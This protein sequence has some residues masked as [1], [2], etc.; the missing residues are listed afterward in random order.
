M[1][2]ENLPNANSSFDYTPEMVAE[3]EKCR[4]DII[5]FAS[6]YFYIIDPDS[7]VGKV[8][9]NL[10]EFQKRVLKGIF[11]NR[12]NV[13]LSPRQASKALAL[14]TPI[15][16][17]N[18][19]TTMG[20]LKDGDVVYG[21][22]GKPCNVVMAHNIRY[23]RPCYEVEFDN[24]EVIVAD[25]DHNWFIQSKRDRD[26]KVVSCGS[27]KT[28]KEL[29]ENFKTKSGEP[30]YRIPS[31]INGV[32][33]EEKDL[34]I[35]P[36]VLG[37]WL[38]DGS[39]DSSRIT[40]GYQYIDELREILSQY[41]RYKYSEVYRE[42][43]NI[44]SIN[45]G[46]IDGKWDKIGYRA[47]LNNDLRN[48]NLLGNKHIP[49][50]YL[51]S[52]R[53]QRLELLKGL[54]D[55]D[56]SIN[57]R[58][59]ARFTNKNENLVNQFKEL[60]ESLG[61]KTTYKVRKTFLNGKQCADSHSIEYYPRE[62][63][64][65]L[66]FKKN[67]IVLQNIQEPE[68]NK[69]NQWHYIKDIRPIQSVPVRC[70][71][72]DSSDNLFLC[73]K[74]FIPTHN[75]TMITIMALH[76]ACFKAYRN[77]VIV[78]NKEATAIEIF[79]RVRLAYEE[80]P[81]W[82]KPGVGEYGKTGCVFDNGSR[83]S[84]STTTGS[85]SRGASVSV[86]IIDEIGW[87]ENHLL[88]EF[89][90]SVYPTISRSRTSKIIAASTPNGVGNLFH[91]L[92]TEAEKGEN[93]FVAHRIEWDE[94]PGRDEEWKLKQIKALGSY[95]SFLQEFGNTFLD[96]SQ[97]SID[98][99][100]FDKLKNECREPK[101]IL[102]E[103]AYKIWEEYDPE[104]IYVI[105][106]DVS[107]GLGLDASVLQ[108]LDVTNPKEII[109]V[110]EYWTNTKGPSEFTN[111]VVDVC[112][113]WGNPL[114]LIERNNQG[115]GV[116]DTLANTHMYQNLV[117]WGAKEAHKNKQNGMISHINTKYKAVENQRYFVNEAQSVVFRNLDTLKEFKMFVR[118]PNGS[119][120]AKSGEHDDRVMA[121]VWALMA[122]YKDITEL[123]FEIEEFDDC[124]KPLVIKPIDQGLH[125]Y[126]SATSIYTNEIV[127]NIEN[128]N[129]SPMLFGGFGGAA[130]SDMAELEAAGWELPDHSVFSN[131]E[132][133]INP[134]QWAVMEKYFG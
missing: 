91:K 33:K 86:L 13:I 41:E 100:L 32:E 62:Y 30:F 89:W 66:N 101:H 104:K 117:S 93:G 121:F 16:T 25:E 22:D 103:G 64:V 7:D 78:A 134:D 131:P 1:G 88:D 72:V 98:E 55:S 133:N 130:V 14:D 44:Y 129:I 21:R 38:G 43:K 20:E 12:M 85:A 57:T 27:V 17:P 120:K 3:I 48:L 40:V 112:G 9:I 23:D 47:S 111:E 67:R 108:I 94:I 68:S 125:Q 83:I 28:T 113:H 31:C 54:M 71:T 69:R 102:K 60:V 61:Y 118:Y 49:K 82:L 105:G 97:Q 79:R 92:Y 95:E 24:G 74:S 123:Y 59:H 36:Y 56:G 37:M 34:V 19:W 8:K 42:N 58:G 45:L 75:T 119:W 6:N 122:L 18:G 73:G 96:N 84:I 50:D 53:E 39:T 106:G 124:D 29:I 109:Q 114:L 65:K 52:S 110:A 46:K 15:P 99:A 127:E 116:C 132:R 10:Y 26:L 87:I 115:T 80:L 2:N 128:S 107:E 77:V 126:R 70:I 35:P 5:H 11:D 81:N 90:K 4:N 51:E 63:V 76:E